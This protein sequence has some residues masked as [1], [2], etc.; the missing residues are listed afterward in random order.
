MNS[1]AT[2]QPSKPELPAMSTTRMRTTYSNMCRGLMTAEEIMLD[3][4]FNPNS[5]GKVVDEPVEVRSRI[6]L[7]VPS[8]VRLHQLLHALLSK[9]QEA[10]EQ[11]QAAA[12]QQQAGPVGAEPEPAAPAPAA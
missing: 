8:A 1:S 3:F 6:V 7:S 10:V 9:R 4:G 11:A 5:G 2:D 12:R